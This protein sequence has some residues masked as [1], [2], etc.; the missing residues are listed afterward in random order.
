MYSCESYI[1][2]IIIY[3]IDVR[4]QQLQNTLYPKGGRNIVSDMTKLTKISISN[5]EGILKIIPMSVAI[6]SR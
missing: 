2:Y 4:Y 5:L 3:I 1:I 6:M